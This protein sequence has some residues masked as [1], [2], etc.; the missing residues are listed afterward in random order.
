MTS[1]L[2]QIKTITRLQLGLADISADAQLAAELGA[3]SVDIVN[4]VAVIEEEF[5][6]FIPEEE[7]ASIATVADLAALVQQYR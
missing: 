4:I 2:D 6:V 5:N 1:L 3:E 7:L